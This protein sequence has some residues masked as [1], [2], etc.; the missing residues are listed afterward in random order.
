MVRYEKR[1]NEDAKR[2]S[3]EKV[4]DD[5]KISEVGTVPKPES[6][7]AIQKSKSVSSAATE[8]DLDV[9]LLGDHGDS[10]DGQGNTVCI[11]Y[12]INLY[13]WYMKPYPK[14]LYFP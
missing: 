3:A 9:F 7:E 10:D 2:I 4:K 12:Y 13:G 14:S 1:Y 8:Q 6:G 5:I 11:Y